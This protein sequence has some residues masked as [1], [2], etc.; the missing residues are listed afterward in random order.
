H[1]RDAGDAPEVSCR[2]PVG[3]DRGQCTPDR[4]DRPAGRFAV[5][6]DRRRVL[7]V[8]DGSGRRGHAQWA[9]ATVA[10]QPHG[11]GDRFENNP[12]GGYEGTQA[13]VVPRRVHGVAAAEIEMQLVGRL[14][15][16]DTDARGWATN[17]I[18]VEKVFTVEDA[19]GYD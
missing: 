14:L 9:E 10:G 1:H 8:H 3:D 18:V 4:V 16:T 13:H 15:H 11:V 7:G 17:A 5:Q 19:I 2:Q 6:A 12:A